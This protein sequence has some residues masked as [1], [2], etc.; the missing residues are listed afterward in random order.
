MLGDSGTG[1]PIIGTVINFLNSVFGGFFGGGGD[2][3]TV[4]EL[5]SMGHALTTTIQAVWSLLGNIGSLLWKALKRLWTD[6]IKKAIDWLLSHVQ[7]L[8]DWLKRHAKAAIDFIKKIKKWYDTHILPQ[9]LR[10]LQM[11]QRVRQILGILRL[12]HVKWA[13]KLDNSLADLQNRIEQAISIVRGNLNGLINWLNA[14]YDPVWLAGRLHVGGF[15][16]RELD[17]HLRAAG[18]HGLDTLTPSTKGAGSGQTPNN[19]TNAIVAAMHQD[20]AGAGGPFEEHGNA[21]KAGWK[22]QEAFGN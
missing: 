5:E 11:I 9:Q 3:A 4:N 20:N 1:P 7:K 8:Y 19:G 15:W 13:A 2:N 17:A 16:V 18:L 21:A 6:Y 10:M 14:I 22:F 12:F